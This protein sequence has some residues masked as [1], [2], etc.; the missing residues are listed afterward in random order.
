MSQS[1]SK[2][3][4]P[5][6]KSGLKPKCS[7]TVTS[8]VMSEVEDKIQR[9]AETVGLDDL[10]IRLDEVV[11]IH[12]ELSRLSKIFNRIYSFQMLMTFLDYFA[13][14]LSNVMSLSV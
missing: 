3:V 9:G 7:N 11:H 12:S 13:N 2:S 6:T 10:H 14:V 8:N 5:I 4:Y 1:F